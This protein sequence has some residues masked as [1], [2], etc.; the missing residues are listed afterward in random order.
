MLLGKILRIDVNSPPPVGE[1]LRDPVR[2]S[3]RRQSA[4]RPGSGAA[5]CPEIFALGFR[6]PWRMNF[7]PG[8]GNLYVGDVGQ[9]QQEEIDVVTLGGNYGWDCLEGEVGHAMTA[10]VQFPIFVP[11]EAVH[12]RSEAQAITGGAVYRGAA[13]PG[14][15]GFYVYGDFLTGRFFAF[16]TEVLNAPVQNL[17][18]PATMVSAFGQGRDGEIYV[19]GFDT[20]S[21]QKIVPGSG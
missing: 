20:P 13:I 14:L 1:D 6:N 16:D 3:V 2:Q 19:V 9:G 18:V 7:D 4:L 17:S 11:P 10:V 12:G 5:P 8:T 21:I 15:Q